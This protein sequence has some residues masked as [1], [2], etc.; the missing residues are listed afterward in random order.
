NCRPPPTLEQR[1]WHETRSNFVATR[2]EHA[3]ERYVVVDRKLESLC[4]SERSRPCDRPDSLPGAAPSVQRQGRVSELT[5]L[6]GA[7]PSAH[8]A[9]QTAGRR[10]RRDV[11]QLIDQRP[12]AL[13]YGLMTRVD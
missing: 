7:A 6:E 5:H 11:V 12:A 10:R 13:R 3:P 4:G 8:S 2:N 9:N 1:R